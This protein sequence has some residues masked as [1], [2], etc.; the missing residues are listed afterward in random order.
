MW[1]RGGLPPRPPS[2]TVVVVLLD[3]LDAPLLS[4]AALRPLLPLAIPNG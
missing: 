4:A 1:H 2:V 3:L